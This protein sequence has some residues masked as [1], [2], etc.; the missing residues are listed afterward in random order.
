M[1]PH[2]LWGTSGQAPLLKT[3]GDKGV[4]IIPYMFVPGKHAEHYHALLENEVRNLYAKW[5]LL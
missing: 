2:T 1:V 4:E 3:L 5:G